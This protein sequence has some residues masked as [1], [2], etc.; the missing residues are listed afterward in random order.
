MRLSTVVIFAGTLAL[1]SCTPQPS[2]P[3]PPPGP[4]AT[5]A[6]PLPPVIDG[7]TY[8]QCCAAMAAAGCDDGGAACPTTLQHNVATGF[9]RFDCA[10]RVCGLSCK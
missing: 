1:W 2:P 9:A 3:V 6:A 5:D 8:A 4:D 7:G 10:C